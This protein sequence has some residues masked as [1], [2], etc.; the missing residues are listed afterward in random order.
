MVGDDLFHE[1]RGDGFDIGGVRHVRIGH[2]GGGVGIDQ[3]HPIAFLAQRLAGLCSRIVEFAGLADD[4]RPRADDQDG[5]DIGAFGHLFLC[6][7]EPSV[8]AGRAW[9]DPRDEALRAG[10]IVG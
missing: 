3:Y 10:Q 6:L 1:L 5:V 7:P 4:D 8:R 9:T 2:D